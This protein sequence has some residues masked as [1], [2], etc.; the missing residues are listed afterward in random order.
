MRATHRP[1]L[2]LEHRLPNVLTQ[3]PVAMP[4]QAAR[5]LAHD[6]RAVLRLAWTACHVMRGAYVVAVLFPGLGIRERQE[7]IGRWSHQVLRA[8][9]VVLS[10]NGHLDSGAQM[11]VANHIS[12]LDVMVLHALCPQARFV[13]KSEVKHWPLVGRLVIGAQTFFV[14]RARPR[15]A[16]QAVAAIAAALLAGGTVAVFPEGTTSNGHAVLPFRSSLL[17]AALTTGVAIRPVALRYTD[18]H[19]RVSRSAPY[20]DDVSLLASLWR[21]ARSERLVVHVNVLPVHAPVG[22]DRRPLAVAL[23]NAIHAALNSEACE[24]SS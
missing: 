7:H 8:L 5:S 20:I 1:D 24:A 3:R 4:R 11:L 23:R 9:G 2:A 16:S 21:T 12:W 13:A 15:Q 19:H 22:S 18:A 6:L 17:Q 14:E 10:P